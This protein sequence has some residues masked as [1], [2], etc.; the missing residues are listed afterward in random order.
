MA[1]S[2]SEFAIWASFPCVVPPVEEAR[3]SCTRKSPG[4]GRS[5]LVAADARYAVKLSVLRWLPTT[6]AGPSGDR[7]RPRPPTCGH[8]SLTRVRARTRADQIGVAAPP[9]GPLPGPT[10]QRVGDL[11]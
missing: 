7:G 3:R 6:R 1:A 8:W 4:A 5:G 10:P 9:A 11:P 2:F